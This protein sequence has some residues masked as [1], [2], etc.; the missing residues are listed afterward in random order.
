MC[1]QTY[2][3]HFRIIVIIISIT[4]IILVIVVIGLSTQAPNSLVF[5]RIPPGR[6]NGVAG[7]PDPPRQR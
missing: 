6:P 7:A 4:V 5:A 3:F 2:R 1:T